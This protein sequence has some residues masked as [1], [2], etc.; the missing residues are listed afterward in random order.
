MDMNE[1]APLAPVG[2]ISPEVNLILAGGI[3]LLFGFVLER[4]GFGS[5]RKLAAQWT[6]RDW[7]VFRVMFSAIVTTLFGALLLDALGLMS[8]ERVLVLS[9]Y[10]PSQLIGGLVMGLGFALAGYCPGTS[11]VALASG[12]WDALVYI[13]GMSAGVVAFAWGWPF[14]EDLYNAGALG[15]TTLAQWWS[16]SPWGIAFGLLIIAGVGWHLANRWELRSRTTQGALD[17]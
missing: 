1:I 11:L 12:R 13:L 4:A 3:G 10:W 7:S 9:T 17:V 2:L 14:W 5:S 16:V 15:K 6:G 8:L